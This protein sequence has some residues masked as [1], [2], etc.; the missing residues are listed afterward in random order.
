MALAS[1]RPRPG[2]RGG[3]ASIRA[4]RPDSA[5]QRLSEVA[6]QLELGAVST[7]QQVAAG[8]REQANLLIS[9]IDLR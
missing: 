4:G 1:L 5:Y 9:S 2:G 3:D 8:L 6:R 7:A